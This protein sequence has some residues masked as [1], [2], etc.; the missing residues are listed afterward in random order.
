M[1][2]SYSW[3]S[4]TLLDATEELRTDRKPMQ[5]GRFEP[6][7]KGKGRGKGQEKSAQAGF[8]GKESPWL[9]QLGGWAWWKP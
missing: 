4:Q 1:S 6:G 5:V 2:G 9:A 3:T 7:A 8:L